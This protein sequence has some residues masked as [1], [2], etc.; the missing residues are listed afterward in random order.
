MILNVEWFNIIIVNELW[1]KNE[2]LFVKVRVYNEDI[3]MFVDI[4]VNVILL[5]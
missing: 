2:G 1:F 4:G 5:S 3:V